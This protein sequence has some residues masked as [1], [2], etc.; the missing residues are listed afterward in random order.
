MISVRFSPDLLDGSARRSAPRVRML[1]LASQVVVA[2]LIV[3]ALLGLIAAH[4][5]S[6]VKPSLLLRSPW[7]SSDVGRAPAILPMESVKVLE[8]MEASEAEGMPSGPPALVPDARTVSATLGSLAQAV[9][10][11]GGDIIELR[12][13]SPRGDLADITLRVE[14]I[15]GTAA[16]IE[17]LL[18]RVVSHAAD[19]ARVDSVTITPLGA[20]VVIVA[21]MVPST[22]P[23]PQDGAL[24]SDADV[25][26]QLSRLAAQSGVELRQL[27]TG[28]ARHDGAVRLRAEGTLAA[29]TELVQTLEAGPS[30]PA[31][32]RSARLGRAAQPEIFQ[33]D[34]SL[35]LREAPVRL[36][37]LGR[38][39]T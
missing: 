30:A 37:S 19:T 3:V 21:T 17:R 11:A 7:G 20:T 5:T 32:L 25:S 18:A 12:V 23:L 13:D 27:D 35:L 28:G 22:A 15:S 24:R 26:V 2:L 8:A 10:V 29:L 9:K 1:H 16:G 31:R 4:D 34:L 33:I 39:R 14:L 38:E 36:A 6:G